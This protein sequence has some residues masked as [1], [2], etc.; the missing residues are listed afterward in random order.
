M[1][2]RL[3]GKSK[4]ETE[5]AV[6][7]TQAHSAPAASKAAGLLSRFATPDPEEPIQQPKIRRKRD[8]VRSRASDVRD[9]HGRTAAELAEEA[10]KDFDIMAVAERANE[11]DEFPA[12]DVLAQEA[13]PV[14]A[15][16][17][18]AAAKPEVVTIPEAAPEADYEDGDPGHI[19]MPG[20]DLDAAAQTQAAR[21][22]FWSKWGECDE[23]LLGYDIN[24]QAL[25]MPAWPDARQN[26]RLVRT[27][28]SLIIASE[29]LSD[30]FGPFSEGGLTNGFGMEVF[31]EVPGWQDVRLKDAKASW[32]FTA[33]EHVARVTAQAKGL[34]ELLKSNRILSIDLPFPAMPGE[35]SDPEDPQM[36][37][38]LV[39]MPLPPR[40]DSMAG[41]PLSNIRAVP[42]TMLTPDELE[43]CLIGGADERQ[44]LSTDL[45]TTGVGH[46]SAPDRMSL[47]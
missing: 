23:T 41:A 43:A 24:P 17:P 5:T 13:A 25:G 14:L 45:M 34:G 9:E 36:P 42:V 46:R 19:V 18:A 7:A 20:A 8:A 2:K 21:D 22:R 38:A 1:L 28:T 32:A 44:S 27:E 12:D 11:I 16:K 39:G 31:I 29:G 15:E 4:L 37:G 35:W 30:P 26:F 40:M 10:N 47:R 33:V 3:L 6:L